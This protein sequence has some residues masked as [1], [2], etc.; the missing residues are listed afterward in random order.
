MMVECHPD[1]RKPRARNFQSRSCGG[2]G[3][4]LGRAAVPNGPS[5]GRCRR[6]GIVMA[7][8]A[9]ALASL[10]VAGV[11]E[12]GPAAAVRPADIVIV[13]AKVWTGD[14]HGRTSARELEPSAI[15]VEGDRIVAI[16][17]DDEI[18]PRIG[19]A[20]KR[21]DAAGRRV[22]PGITDSHT[23]IISGGFQLDR[24]NLRDVK[25]REEFV[26]MI[27]DAAK[28]RP[29]G[30]WVLGGRWSVE[31]WENPEPPRAAWLDAV[32]G[33]RPV[34][35]SRMD[36]HQA[37]ANLAALK[38]AG[39]DASG[40]A[41]PVGGEIERDPK[42][43]EPT[44]ILKES[45]MGL[46]SR[47]VPRPSL[48]QRHAALRRAMKHANSLGVTSV[49]DMCDWDDLNVFRDLA[50]ENRLT[51]RITAYVTSGD[52]VADVGRL[53]DLRRSMTRH[54]A[55]TVAGFKGYIDGSMGS[56]TAYMR[57]PYADAGPDMLHP[58]GQLTAFAVDN[59]SFLSHVTAADA[60]GMQLTV[61]A[62]GD[63][64]NHLVLDAYEEAARRNGPRDRRH[65]IEHAQ[66]LIP[67]DIGRFAKL[68]VVASMQPFHKADDGR[69][70]EM[71]LGR[72]RLKGS[73]AFRQLVDAG[74]LLVFGSDWPV[75]T[76]NPFAGIDA[77][78]NARTLA[79][80]V[81]LP[82]HS[83]KVEEALHAYTSAPCQAIGRERDL[84]AIEPGKLADL[85]IL[86]TDPLT[87][88][89][90]DLAKVTP[91]VTIMG[92]KVVYEAN[93]G[94]EPRP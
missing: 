65:R 88:S 75:V 46:V 33:D 17:T 25:S 79:G 11:Q 53:L 70:V 16:G 44:G 57:E 51:V 39:I 40:P 42:T 4:A 80:D 56:R 26:R 21:I 93:R 37:L 60:K 36:G 43:K 59:D 62:I 94:S 27:A 87:I 32:I 71:V 48:Q 64:G 2:R 10:D 18:K 45:A 22:I 23:H 31:S 29:E 61:H 9:L 55:F 83:L 6:R 68:G 35:L 69:Y 74:A 90:D 89:P 19:P 8:V 47:H 20:T 7:C 92:G 30:E 63:E 3:G 85:V 12:K 82:D 1:R 58:R 78:V 41:D 15:A 13:H 76:L 28:S 52:W 81:W 14:D 38:L 91:A 49:H 73:Y 66:H 84:G 5:A 67:S 72:E 24:L 77:A 34:F 54:P 50:E 86:Q